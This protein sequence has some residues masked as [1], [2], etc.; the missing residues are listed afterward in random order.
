MDRSD[1]DRPAPET[2]TQSTAIAQVTIVRYA[3]CMATAPRRRPGDRWVRRLNNR[4][5]G[6]VSPKA[7][8]SFHDPRVL[9]RA[10]EVLESRQ[11]STKRIGDWHVHHLPNGNLVIEDED[12][13]VAVIFELPP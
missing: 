1:P 3:R 2:A 10:L 11:V 6:V 12:G 7:V 13:V 5:V 4:T 8:T 9:G